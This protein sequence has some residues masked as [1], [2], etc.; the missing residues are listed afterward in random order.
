MNWGVVLDNQNYAYFYADY[1]TSTS[2][3]INKTKIPLNCR[4]ND[5]TWNFIGI[6]YS[7]AKTLNAKLMHK[8]CV[9]INDK[10]NVIP[11]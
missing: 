8:F 11:C 9:Y 2:N 1:G 4:I 10:Y 6:T 3:N 5:K 7:G